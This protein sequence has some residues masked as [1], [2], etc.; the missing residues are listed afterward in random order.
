[1]LQNRNFIGTTNITGILAFSCFLVLM[2]YSPCK[3]EINTAKNLYPEDIISESAKD[4]IAQEDSS[5]NSA[6]SI[7]EQLKQKKLPS[8]NYPYINLGLGVGF[9]NNVNANDSIVFNSILYTGNIN[10]GLDLGFTG[11]LSGGYQFEDGRVELALGY[12]TFGTND[13]TLTFKQSFSQSGVTINLGEDKFLY[14]ASGSASYFSVMVNGYY[15]IPTGNKFRPYIGVGIGYANVSTSDIEIALNDVV[16]IS[17]S[18]GNAGTFAYQGKL[19]LSYEAA[20]KGT[21]YL[22]AAY[23]G[24]TGFS[25]NGVNYDAVGATR[26]VVGWRQGF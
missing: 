6:P 19:G 17:R 25:A 10:Q 9:P 5:S 8:K 22:E 1:M 23:L 16:S 15:D 20:P 24:T 12:G 7:A 14:S 3:A 18:G 13:G 2:N 21:V 26:V 4:L 11:E